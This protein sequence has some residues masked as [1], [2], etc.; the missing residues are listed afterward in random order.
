MIEFN[1]KDFQLT[2]I[3]RES[4]LFNLQ[5]KVPYRVYGLKTEGNSPVHLSYNYDTVG[6]DFDDHLSS[7]VDFFETNGIEF[8]WESGG[9]TPK[10]C[11]G[12]RRDLREQVILCSSI[13][14]TII[15]CLEGRLAIK[16]GFKVPGLPKFPTAKQTTAKTRNRR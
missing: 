16:P 9:G 10:V 5:T 12:L 7:L 2:P 11:I 4:K 13:V 6:D 8:V 3:R 14:Q 1:G 15:Y